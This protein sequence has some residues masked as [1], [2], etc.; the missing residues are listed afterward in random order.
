MAFWL[1][2]FYSKLTLHEFKS[3][4]FPKTLIFPPVIWSVASY[5]GVFRGARIS[6]VP[7]NACSIENNIPFPSL[8]NHIVPSKF[9]KVGF[10]RRV[11]R[12]QSICMRHWDSFMTSN[13]FQTQRDKIKIQSDFRIIRALHNLSDNLREHP[14]FSA[15]V[16]PTEKNLQRERSDDRKYVC[17][18]QA[19]LAKERK[20]GNR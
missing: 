16:S 17:G 11:T 18:S 1:L 12:Y 9:W 3:R 5:S 15:L 14:V 19:N 13:K 10:D 2:P 7:T 20:E 4:L 8:A 6:S